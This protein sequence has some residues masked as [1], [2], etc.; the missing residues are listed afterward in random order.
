MDPAWQRK[1]MDHGKHSAARF[2]AVYFVTLCAQERLKNTFCQ[3]EAAT[4]LLSTAAHYHQLGRC[5]VR[6]FL[7]MPDHLHALLGVNGE[8]SL[9]A[10][11]KDLKRYAARTAGLKWQRNY[12]DHRI[13]H[14]ESAREKA[15]YILHNPVRAGLVKRWEDWPHVYLPTDGEG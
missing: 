2:G 3:P 13:R 11:V 15:D 5:Y 10:I 6:V 1:K 14:D 12:F 8:D 9:S 4:V 7:L